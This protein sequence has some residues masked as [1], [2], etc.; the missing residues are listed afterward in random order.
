[1][2]V[3][4]NHGVAFNATT[5][6]GMVTTHKEDECRDKQRNEKEKEQ[7]NFSQKVEEEECRLF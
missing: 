6:K 2:Q 4:V 3:N 7:T 5:V 1:M